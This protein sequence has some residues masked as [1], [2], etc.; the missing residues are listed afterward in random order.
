M[1]APLAVLMVSIYPA[2]DFLFSHRSASALMA[3]TALLTAL[4]V[5]SAVAVLAAI[6]EL[7]PNES[8]ASGL[9][10]A[11][12]ISVSLFGGTTQFVIAW[13]IGVTG[14]PLSPAFYVIASSTITLWAMLQV[15]ETRGTELPA[16][17][18]L[19]P[20]RG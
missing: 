13:L 4:T 19:A 9:S 17:A 10:I 11:Y 2:F 6:T 16:V 8:R 20:G 7:L 12:A 3:V 14:N 5:L 18:A 1:I 15:P